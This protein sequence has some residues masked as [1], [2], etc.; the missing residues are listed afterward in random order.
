MPISSHARTSSV[1]PTSSG[2][3]PTGVATKALAL[4]WLAPTQFSF[5]PSQL[6]PAPA[7]LSVARLLPA[8]HG[9]CR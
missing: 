3:G 1:L 9:H 7:P 6:S 5:G 2:T 4:N 8:D